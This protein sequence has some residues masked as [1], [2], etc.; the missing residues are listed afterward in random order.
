MVRVRDDTVVVGAA[1]L[2]ACKWLSAV[3]G[4]ESARNLANTRS[5]DVRAARP[6]RKALKRTFECLALKRLRGTQ[7]EFTA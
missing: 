3:T 6:A 5:A 2:S 1:C 7:S 4:A